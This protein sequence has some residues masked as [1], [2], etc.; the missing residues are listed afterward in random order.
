MQAALRTCECLGVQD[1]WLI[2]QPHQPGYTARLP[3]APSSPTASESRHSTAAETSS[4][5]AGEDPAQWLTVRSFPTAQQCIAALREER[6]TLWSTDLSQSAVTLD[7]VLCE[8]RAA[9]AHGSDLGIQMP[10]GSVTGD[11]KTPPRRLA[12][13]FSGS[14]GEGVSRELLD[15]AEK[16]VYLPLH[17]GR[18]RAAVHRSFTLCCFCRLPGARGR[19]TCASCWRHCAHCGDMVALPLAQAGMHTVPIRGSARA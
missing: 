4:A 10:D 12:V 8:G 1:V 17:G 3:D 13:A 19:N 14:E 5:A 18:H 16:R 7:A 15:A 6:C 2:G 11:D 9:D